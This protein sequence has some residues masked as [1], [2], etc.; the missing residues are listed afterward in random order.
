MKPIRNRFIICFWYYSTDINCTLEYVN[1]F[2]SVLRG[3]IPMVLI[4][5]K[6]CVIK[7]IFFCVFLITFSFLIFFTK[8]HRDMT[9]CIRKQHVKFEII[10]LIKSEEILVLMEGAWYLSLPAELKHA[11]TDNFVQDEAISIKIVGKFMY[12]CG[13]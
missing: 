12:I 6:R 13:M 11:C 2:R 8:I 4:Q 7:T 10:I 5:D 9:Y 3:I 1:F